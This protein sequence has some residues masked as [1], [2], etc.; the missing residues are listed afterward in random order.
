MLTCQLRR[1]SFIVDDTLVEVEHI[2]TLGYSSSAAIIYLPYASKL[3]LNLAKGF[4]KQVVEEYPE[5]QIYFG[6][7]VGIY[8]HYDTDPTP[9]LVHNS[10]VSL[11]Q[12]LE[13]KHAS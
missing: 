11:N 4:M 1:L 6:D 13:V 10:D 12:L 5:L 9:D 3:D 7:E 2:T 8:F